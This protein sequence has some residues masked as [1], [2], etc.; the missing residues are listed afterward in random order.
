MQIGHWISATARPGSWYRV[1][2]LIRSTGAFNASGRHSSTWAGMPVF[3]D[4]S[5]TWHLF[6]APRSSSSEALKARNQ[7]RGGAIAGRR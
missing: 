2:T 1:G 5:Q 4:D 7:W 6:Y 3:D